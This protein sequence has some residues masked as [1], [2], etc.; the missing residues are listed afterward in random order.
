M[1]LF[2]A[3]KLDNE[4]ILE[5]Q[6]M[7]ARMLLA[8]DAVSKRIRGAK[9]ILSYLSD[10]DAHKARFPELLSSALSA[11][12]AYVLATESTSISAQH[13]WLPFNLSDPPRL[14]GEK[15]FLLA[16]EVSPANADAQLR[17]A[18]SLSERLADCPV[19]E[20]ESW[21]SQAE[22]NYQTALVKDPAN[23]MAIYRYALFLEQHMN[24]LNQVCP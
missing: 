18:V 11:Y 21:A 8:S 3:R 22:L 17:L 19:E 12:G 6:I 9:K 7:H 23:V 20:R 16:L 14:C 1:D 15:L 13:A 5:S 2:E 10:F 24:D 4:L